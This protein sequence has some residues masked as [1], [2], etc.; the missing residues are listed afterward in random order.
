M[1]KEMIFDIQLFDDYQIYA[2]TSAAE[3][4]SVATATNISKKKGKE[5]DYASITASSASGTTGT[6]IGAGAGNDSIFVESAAA[7]LQLSIAG[8]RGND[9]VSIASATRTAG[10]KYIYNNGDGK[11][12]IVGWNAADS[13]IL[14]TTSYSTAMSADGNDFIVKVGAEYIPIVNYIDRLPISRCVTHIRN[15]TDD[16]IGTDSSR[17]EFGVVNGI[18]IFDL[19]AVDYEISERIISRRQIDVSC[20]SD[21]RY[22]KLGD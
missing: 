2:G 22:E 12:T 15:V 14:G 20:R 21:R 4:I 19:S 5:T 8:G 1:T 16:L 6:S 17:R 7:G 11:D 9:Y 10:N 13:L 18:G 3:S